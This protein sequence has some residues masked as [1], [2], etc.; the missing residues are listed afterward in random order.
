MPVDSN[1]AVMVEVGPIVPPLTVVVEPVPIDC[2]V[3]LDEV[4]VSVS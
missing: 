1:V 3:I 2:V 4:R